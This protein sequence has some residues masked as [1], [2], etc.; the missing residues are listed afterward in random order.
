MPNRICAGLLVCFLWV[1]LFAY[2][3]QAQ[4]SST[5]ISAVTI[6]TRPMEGNSEAYELLVNNAVVLRYRSAAGGYSAEERARIILQ[7]FRDIPSEQL[8]TQ[9]IAAGTINGYPVIMLGDRLLITV[10]QAD[11]EANDTT[12]PGLAGVWANNLSNALNTPAPP[13][14]AGPAPQSPAVSVVV[15]QEPEEQ[16]L[17]LINQERAKAGVKALQMDFGLVAAAR[18]KSQDMVDNNYFSHTS[19]TFGD[20]FAMLKQFNISY[21]YAGENL[22]GNQ[23]VKEAHESLMNS[24]GH[25]T[26]I[27]NP[28]FTHAGIGIVKG[29]TYGMMF[30][31]FFI[32]N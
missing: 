27:L 16:M 2:P 26:N 9:P 19:P 8:F 21:S 18:A 14:P 15:P 1:S 17:A 29:G 7:R 3:L 5:Y 25:R 30:T 12:G 28:D 6:G 22:A 4:E 24:P 23:S 13:P 20:S 32:G 11:W 31:Q 10:T